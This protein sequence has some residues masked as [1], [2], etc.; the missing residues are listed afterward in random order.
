MVEG[1]EEKTKRAECPRGNL[2]SL[3]L[4]NTDKDFISYGRSAPTSTHPGGLGE[5]LRDV[6]EQPRDF[7]RNR[8]ETHFGTHDDVRGGEPKDLHMLTNKARVREGAI[9]GQEMRKPE[10]Q[11]TESEALMA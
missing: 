10:R 8:A 1:I 5:R 3:C 11:V 4:I 7:R 6:T 9:I 2:S